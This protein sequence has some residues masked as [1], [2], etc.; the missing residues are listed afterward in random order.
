[1][2]ESCLPKTLKKKII[3]LAIICFGDYWLYL[4]YFLANSNNYNVFLFDVAAFFIIFNCNQISYVFTVI[5]TAHH[6]DYK[7]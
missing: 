5:G 6:V 3:R 1:M 2:S 4:S 7:L